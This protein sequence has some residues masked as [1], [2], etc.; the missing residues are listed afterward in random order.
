MIEQTVFNLG[1]HKILKIPVQTTQINQVGS[2][3]V[4]HYQIKKGLLL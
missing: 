4:A 2:I 1:N 3:F